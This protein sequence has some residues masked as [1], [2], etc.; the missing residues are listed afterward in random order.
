M[1]KNKSLFLYK[2]MAGPDLNTIAIVR[3]LSKK[4]RRARKQKHEN[5]FNDKDFT[6]QLE[7]QRIK[8]EAKKRQDK[9]NDLLQEITALQII[10]ADTSIKKAELN[11]IFKGIK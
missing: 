9:I 8:E 6:K 2:Y 7:E 1:N 11:K 3:S 5:K 10:G 4:Q